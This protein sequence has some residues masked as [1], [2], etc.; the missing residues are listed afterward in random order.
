MVG[1]PGDISDVEIH[2]CLVLM[3]KPS[4]PFVCHHD[5]GCQRGLFVVE[6]FVLV[7][8]VLLVLH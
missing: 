3:Y 1:L 7:F 4:E 5:V 2:Y 8:H 6:D